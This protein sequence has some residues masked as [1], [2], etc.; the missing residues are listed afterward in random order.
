MRLDPLCS[1]GVSE[2]TANQRNLSEWL[3]GAYLK[4]SSSKGGQ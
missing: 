2:G 3:R 4:V 1:I